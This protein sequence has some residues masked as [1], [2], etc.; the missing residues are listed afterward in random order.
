LEVG[1]ALFQWDEGGEGEL[2]EAAGLMDKT[3]AWSS[4]SAYSQVNEMM[5]GSGM[6]VKDETQTQV[7]TPFVRE[8]P[9][10]SAWGRLH[11]ALG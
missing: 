6:V 11:P 8:S 5:V 7:A 2:Q 1:K 3:G 4:L 9:L 10:S